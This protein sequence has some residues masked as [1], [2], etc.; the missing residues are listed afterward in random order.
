MKESIKKLN[1]EQVNF[2]CS[3]CNITEDELY[4]MSNEQLEGIVF[5]KMLDI[6]IEESCTTEGEFD[7]PRCSIAS[8]IVTLL[9]ATL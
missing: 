9:S 6:E 3:E 7:T 5:E 1:K 2:I 4:Q 8:D